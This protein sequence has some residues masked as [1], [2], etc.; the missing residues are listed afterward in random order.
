MKIKILIILI[1][2][3]LCYDIALIFSLE[4]IYP[5]KMEIFFKCEVIKEKES[6]EYYDKYIVKVIQN[7][8]IKV[9]K[10]TKLILYVKK[11]K[12]FLPGDI[13]VVK[14]DFEKG[15]ISR[16][17]GGFNY[18]NYLKQNKIYGIVFAEEIEQI[19][20][21]KD[22]YYNFFKIR[23]SLESKINKLY[24]DDYGSFLKSLLIGNKSEL[25]EEI[26]KNFQ[27]SNISHILAISGLHIS[28]ILVGVNFILEKII[29]SK[30]I[31]NSF[32]IIFLLFFMLLTGNS[33]SCMRAC[34]M[35][36]FAILCSTFYKRNDFY[37]S[38]IISIFFIIIINPYNIFN[39]GMWLSYCGTIGI[40][41]IYNFLYKILRKVLNLKNKKVELNYKNTQ[42]DYLKKIAI[43]IKK[44]LL[45]S[46]TLCISAQIFIIP[47]M[48]Y[49]FNNFSLTFFISN[50]I[51]SIFIGYILAIGYISIFISFIFFP[52]SEFISYFEKIIID[53]IFNTANIVSKMPFSKIYVITPSILLIIL[54]YI[55][56]FIF[57]IYFK[58]NKFYI[59]R[60]LLS[61]PKVK[62]KNIFN[63]IIK[64]SKILKK[65][66]VVLIIITIITN[67]NKFNFNL[68][69]YFVDVGQGDCS[70]II[71]PNGKRIL[72]DGG[73]GNS[74]KYD[75]GEKV[76]FPY[77]LDRKINKIDYL[78]ASH[79]DS[80]H[81]GGLIYIVENMKVKN[82]LIGIQPESS[83]QLEK[84]IEIAN[85]K[86][87]KITLLERGDDIFIDK[88][89]KLEVLWPDKNNLIYE[90]TINNNSLVFKIK[91]NNFSML[92]TGDIEEIAEKAILK[93]Y[94]DDTEKL[95]S[96]ILKVAHH[97]SK[98][99]SVQDFL[100]AVS[101][102]IALIGV[103]KNN[104]FGHP[105]GDVIER[106]E[107][108]GIK[109]YR[110]DQMGEIPININKNGKIHIR[111]FIKER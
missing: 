37:S 84:L 42:K 77:L 35:N 95:K 55:M 111:K 29:N 36:I 106:L 74:N 86:K 75:Y 62:W 101:P 10:N 26:I 38:L 105:N 19:S 45:K 43:N 20:Q 41:L 12:E 61:F 85:S 70:F 11:D 59:I 67:T 79:A 103:R 99:S 16:N 30:K 52:L 13:L 9:S 24:E 107:N 28:F 39:V 93:M 46:L 8:S 89:I 60:I 57:I 81:I 27:D 94:Y 80:D 44:F 2:M 31:R 21:R 110:T 63:N 51:T 54:Y 92:F 1:I 83:K 4:K 58:K 49:V 40:V 97:G 25:D 6:K 53:I 69:I 71:T 104:N 14:G 72:I 56:I 3:G 50:I 48:I 108:C 5:E 7:E 91:Y 88:N 33:V 78:I 82:I 73:E 47:I 102:Q 32:L 98:S 87:I 66:F 22:I 109:I 65:F 23:N 64:K 100:D 90:N 34:I 68:K 17:Y 96:T 15:E 76:L 18:R